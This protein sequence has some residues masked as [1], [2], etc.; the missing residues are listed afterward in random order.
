MLIEF[1]FWPDTLSIQGVFASP[2]VQLDYGGKSSILFDNGCPK[3][4]TPL[5]P[6]A[7]QDRAN[8]GRAAA[9][10]AQTK[11]EKGGA[12]YALLK[13]GFENTLF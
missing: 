11:E 1:F 4:Y 2:I 12:T 8:D 9:K 10:N 5:L 7:H 13:G 6:L 3:K